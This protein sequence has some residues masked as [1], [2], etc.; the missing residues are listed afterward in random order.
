MTIVIE[1]F[2]QTILAFF[3]IFFVTRIIGR[4]QIAQ[5]TL[6][7]YIN[8]ITFGS[9]AATLATDLNQRTWHHIWGL[10]LF[11]ALT[12]LMAYIR[13]KHRRISKII[14]GEPV[15][16]IIDGRILEKNLERFSYTVD[17]LTHLLRKKDVFDIASVQYGILETTGEIS[18][19]KNAQKE[20]IK[21][22]DLNLEIKQ[23]EMPTEIIVMGSILYENM[24]K[25]N[26]TAKW[27]IDQL[28]I[29][30]IKDIREVF[31]ASVDANLHI[32]IDR[33]KDHFHSHDDI[34]EEQQ[35]TKKD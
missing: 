3:S 33:F 31:Y 5:L 20:T 1:V 10:F 22:E 2:L 27:L 25:R 18:I 28:H 23:E 4:Q 29:M 7:D 24:M 35:S 9:I 30:N 16:V 12:Y 15:V 13:L 6:F 34:T 8:G 11:G 32:Y 26:I 21:T 14:Q 19:L 17:D